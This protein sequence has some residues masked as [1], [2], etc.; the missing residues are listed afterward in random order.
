MAVSINRGS[1]LQ[2]SL[3]QSH[4]ALRSMVGLLNS[5]TLQFLVGQDHD[6]FSIQNPLSTSNTAL[7]SITLTK[8]H[9]GASC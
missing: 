8:S 2:V 1:L 9:I 4:S 7:P 5:W 6:V 3:N